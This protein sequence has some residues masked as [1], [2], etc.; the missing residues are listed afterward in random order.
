MQNP[1]FNAIDIGAGGKP[2]IGKAQK[3]KVSKTTGG[4]YKV[5]PQGFQ[6]KSKVAFVAPTKSKLN[7]KASRV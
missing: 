1:F 6:P 5:K 2:K 7:L 4:G 3:P